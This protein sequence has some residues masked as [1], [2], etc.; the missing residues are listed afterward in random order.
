MP[1]RNDTM[2][3]QLKNRLPQNEW[4]AAHRMMHAIMFSLTFLPK[5]ESLEAVDLLVH[6]YGCIRKR[7]YINANLIIFKSLDRRNLD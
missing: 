2:N 7:T 6:I 3:T 1:I 5:G 4:K